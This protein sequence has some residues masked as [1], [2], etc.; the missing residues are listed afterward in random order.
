MMAQA[1]GA[2]GQEFKA[3]L[4]IESDDIEQGRFVHLAIIPRM[5][6]DWFEAQIKDYEKR[7]I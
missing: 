4:E 3:A 7:E 5:T 6:R 2:L 1:R